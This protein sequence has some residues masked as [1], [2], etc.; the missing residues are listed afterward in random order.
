MDS[1]RK[2]GNVLSLNP[3]NFF[4]TTDTTI[5]SQPLHESNFFLI[6]FLSDP[7]PALVTKFFFIKI[8]QSLFLSRALFLFTYSRPILLFYLIYFFSL[9]LSCSVI[10]MHIIH[11]LSSFL[12]LSFSLFLSYIIYQPSYLLLTLPEFF[13][14]SQ[15][16][17]LV[18]APY[19]VEENV[20]RICYL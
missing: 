6:L 9:T 15:Y 2:I 17:C 14:P 12:S 10:S 3:I 4:S 5:Q 7:L 8:K 18:P 1:A 11:S 13:I 19:T 20:G 16:S